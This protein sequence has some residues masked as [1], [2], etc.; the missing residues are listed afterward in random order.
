MYCM[1]LDVET[2]V[3]WWL[4]FTAHAIGAVG[5]DLHMVPGKSAPDFLGTIY[6]MTLSWLVSRAE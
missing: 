1:L 6:R 3:G 5:L 4:V 2:L